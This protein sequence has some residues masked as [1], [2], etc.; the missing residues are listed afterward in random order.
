MP[1]TPKIKQSQYA[2]VQLPDGQEILKK[3]NPSFDTNGPDV[4]HVLGHGQPEERRDNGSLILHTAVYT[5]R[6]NGFESPNFGFKTNTV[7]TNKSLFDEY[8]REKYSGP[9]SRARKN[10]A[11][12]AVQKQND[13]Q[14]KD[15]VLPIDPSM[16]MRITKKPNAAFKNYAYQPD[17]GNKLG[18][19]N[20]SVRD[21]PQARSA[22]AAG[23]YFRPANTAEYL[24]QN[25]RDGEL[26]SGDQQNGRY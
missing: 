4:G 7:E 26:V 22:M 17:S 19:G 8:D 21:R 20:S 16:G 15:D 11:S 1:N 18:G 5:N 2:V 10:H 25:Q 9:I 23:T 3:R 6:T 12:G 13:V 24:H 14:K